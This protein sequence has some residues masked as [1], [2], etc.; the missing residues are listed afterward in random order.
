MTTDVISRT[1]YDHRQILTKIHGNPRMAIHNALIKLYNV[2]QQLFC[3]KFKM[4]ILFLCLKM[5]NSEFKIVGL[6]KSHY[7]IHYVKYIFT[8][9]PKIPMYCSPPS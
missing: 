8:M 1:T 6:L 7:E 3:C 9:F 2:Q 5:L 4:K